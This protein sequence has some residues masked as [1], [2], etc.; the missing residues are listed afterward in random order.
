MTQNRSGSSKWLEKT[1]VYIVPTRLYRQCKF[2]LDLSPCDPKSIGFLLSSWT[3]YMW[4]L[5]LVWQKSVSC[6]QC[7][8]DKV[9]NLTLTFD[10]VTQNLYGSSS[11]HEQCTYEVWMWWDKNCSLYRVHKESAKD[12]RTHSRTHSLT[13]PQTKGRISIFQQTLLRGIKVH[14]C[15]IWIWYR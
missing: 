8:I 14:T 10:P 12:A 1:V 9:P 6:P 2:D 15:M 5:K 7:F 13:Q 3:T 4:S 11:Y